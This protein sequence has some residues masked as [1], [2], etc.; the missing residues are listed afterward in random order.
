MMMI[1]P[2]FHLHMLESSA[3]CWD[4]ARRTLG[5]DTYS[6]E[7]AACYKLF[8]QLRACQRVIAASSHAH[9][10]CSTMQ[11]AYGVY[12]L[13]HPLARQVCCCCSDWMHQKEEEL[14][15]EFDTEQCAI[16]L[17]MHA[18]CSAVFA[19][20]ILAELISPPPSRYV[21]PRKTSALKHAM[22]RAEMIVVR[23][24]A[25]RAPA[26]KHKLQGSKRRGRR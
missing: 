20:S 15:V 5:S 21:L 10:L 26:S 3:F 4:E 14:P 22:E 6:P 24:P 8:M 19:V 2:A 11:L 12:V 17:P 13:A 9:T 23:T 16:L 7:Y 25:Q 1:H 18:S